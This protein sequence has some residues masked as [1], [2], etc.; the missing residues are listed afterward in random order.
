MTLLIFN[1]LQFLLL[2]IISSMQFFKS[3]NV[4]PFIIF[5]HT[6]PCHQI[7]LWQQTWWQSTLWH[8]FFLPLKPGNIPLKRMNCNLKNAFTKLQKIIPRNTLLPL[9]H[10]S[11]NHFILLLQHAFVKFY[12]FI[13]WVKSGI[14]INGASVIVQVA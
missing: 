7:K 14:I 2:I 10:Q 9:I 11:R 6:K 1:N 3:T 8:L 13:H 5:C 4:Q 12:Y